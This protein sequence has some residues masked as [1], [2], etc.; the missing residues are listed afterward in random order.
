VTLFLFDI[1]AGIVADRV[2]NG[3]GFSFRKFLK[4][5]TFLVFY[6]VIIAAIYVICYLQG[7]TDEGL[8]LLKTVTYV[9]G[10]FYFSNITKNLHESYPGNRFFS[11]LFFVLSVDVL[12]GRIPALQ[13]FLRAEKKAAG[14]NESGDGRDGGD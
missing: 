9:C 13:K 14:V 3:R 2:I 5:V 11:F 12:T 4:S 10:Y 7:D 6:V 8:L 1:A